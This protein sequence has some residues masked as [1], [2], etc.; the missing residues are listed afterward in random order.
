MSDIHADLGYGPAPIT[1]RDL[2]RQHR[3]A[4][5]PVVVE[6]AR[7]VRRAV[8]CAGTGEAA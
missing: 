1:A 7:S 2:L 8:M 6:P 5:D 4:V 3:E